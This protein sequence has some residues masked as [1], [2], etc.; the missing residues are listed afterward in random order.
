MGHLRFC[1]V[2][3]RPQDNV[4][5]SEAEIT[6]CGAFGIIRLFLIRL[7]HLEF[8]LSERALIGAYRV[9]SKNLK[10]DQ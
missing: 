8:Y 1:A 4:S 3:K 7:K 5:H 2:V 10:N 6:I 9:F